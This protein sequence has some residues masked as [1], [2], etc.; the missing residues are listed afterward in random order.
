MQYFLV[1]ISLDL[2]QHSNIKVE[3]MAMAMFHISFLAQGKNHF[4]MQSVFDL[5]E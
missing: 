4:G 1:V 3:V 5:W 2:K